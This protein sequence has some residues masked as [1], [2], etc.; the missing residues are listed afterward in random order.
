MRK[1]ALAGS[2]VILIPFLAISQVLEPVKWSF[3]T[4]QTGPGEATLLLIAK[5]DKGW[6]LYSQDIPD[7]G[8]RP[9]VFTFNP[10]EGYSLVGNVTEP[11]G[12]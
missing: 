7:G 1:A 9:T 10:G 12:V 8:P 3:K 4:E 5:V 6:H 2:L 11:K